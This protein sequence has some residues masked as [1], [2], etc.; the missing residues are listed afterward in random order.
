M[1]NRDKLNGCQGPNLTCPPSLSVNQERVKALEVFS[2]PGSRAWPA[3]TMRHLLFPGPVGPAGPGLPW[4][5]PLPA[6]AAG[7]RRIGP[8]HPAEA[9]PSLQE[10]GP[11]GRCFLRAT[12]LT[13]GH[14]KRYLQSESGQAKFKRGL[15]PSKCPQAGDSNLQGCIL[16]ENPKIKNTGGNQRSTVMGR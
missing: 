12:R 16:R 8:P 13:P 9:G 11:P 10:K 3:E 2:G 4:R 1:K 15:L 7:G 14:H 5:F 6:G